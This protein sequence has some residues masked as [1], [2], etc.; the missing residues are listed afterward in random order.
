MS[1]RGIIRQSDVRL[2]CTTDDPIDSLTAHRKIADDPG[3]D[4][5]VLPTFRPDKAMN[6][7]KPGFC[8]YINKLSEM[9]SI[10]IWD[11]D[12]LMQALFARIDH[13]AEHGCRVSDHALDRIIYAASD[14]ATLNNILAKVMSNQS[15]ASLEEADQF[16]TAVLLALAEKYH[17]LGWVMQIHFGCL[18]NNSE[19]MFDRLGPDTGFDSM[20]DAG[21]AEALAALLNA[22]ESRGSLP[23]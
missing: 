17:E 1:V 15:A 20:N 9:A 11:F 19:K 2:I 16:K 8:Q 10:T 12:S 13:F 14:K 4:F 18:R 7:D 23:L 5:Q 22:M 21:G 3:C 6:I